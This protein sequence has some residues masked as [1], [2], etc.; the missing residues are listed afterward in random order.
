[1]AKRNK[2]RKKTTSRMLFEEAREFFVKRYSND[3]TRKIYIR[4]YRRFID[5]C[6]SEYD[7]QSKYDCKKH[8]QDYADYLKE[9]GY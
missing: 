6:R 1:M 7:S 2:V 3:V 5:F 4:N 8:I 9:K